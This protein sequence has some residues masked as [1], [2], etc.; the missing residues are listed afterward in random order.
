MARIVLG[1]GTSHT[2]MASAPHDLWQAHGRVFDTRQKELLAADG[3]TYD[4]DTLLKNADPALV[5]LADPKHY[6]DRFERCQTAIARLAEE[7]AAAAPDMAIVIGEDQHEHFFDDHMPAMLVYWGDSI[8]VKELKGPPNPPPTIAASK[9]AYGLK[10]TSYPVAADLGRHLIE[11]L[12]EQEFDVSHS[13]KLPREDGVGHAFAFIYQRIMQAHVP[14]HVPVFLNTYYPPNQPSPKRCYDFGRAIRAAVANWRP[15]IK[16]AVI[17]SGGLSHFVVNEE[18]DRSVLAAMA[19]RDADALRRVPRMHMNSG[20]SE[21]LNW[22]A[23]AGAVE[24][25]DM[26]LLDYIPAYR[27]PAGTGVGLAFALWK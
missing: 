4:Y 7:Y 18:L 2:P 25:L 19:T 10:E 27:S 6:A 17:A 8:P 5:D 14:P 15:D 9:W 1:I 11:S 20:T 21:I 26:E 3:K 12:I 13:R 23:A 24:E 16:V 22:I